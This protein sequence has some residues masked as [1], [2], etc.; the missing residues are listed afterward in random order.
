MKLSDL[1]KLA[2]DRP[3]SSHCRITD[4]QIKLLDHINALLD[5]ADA[6]TEVCRDWDFEGA[7]LTNTLHIALN[8]TLAE[9]NRGDS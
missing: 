5:I 9:L 6:A 2:K 7:G 4:G 8:D 3:Y 1:R